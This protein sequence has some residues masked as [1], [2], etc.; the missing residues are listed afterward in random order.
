MNGLRINQG[1]NQKVSGNKWKWTWN[2]PNLW[3]TQKAAL[4]GKFIAM[5]A[6]LKK[7]ETFQINDLT[8]HL[9]NLE[10]QQQTKHRVSRKNRNSQDPSWIKWHTD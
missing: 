8:L 5:Q 10:E 4:R 6:Y 1:I 2:N 3:E 9:K 7:T